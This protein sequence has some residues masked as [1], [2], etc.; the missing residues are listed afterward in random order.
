[1]FREAKYNLWHAN[2]AGRRNLKRGIPA[3]QAG[4]PKYNA[5]ADDIDFQIEADFIGLM[6]PGLY[7]PAIDIGMRAGRVMNYGDGI[8]G[9]IFVSCMYAAG[10]FESDPRR[11]VEQG[12][13]CIPAKS[14]YA[15]L[16]VDLLN[17]SK[18]YPGDWKKA[19]Q[20][21]E[22]KWDRDDVCPNGA[23]APFNID[24]KLNG[25]YIALGLLYGQRDFGRTIEISTRAG[26][27]SD[28]NPASAAGILGVMLGYKGIPDEWK[29]GIDALADKK[30]NFTDFSFHG[31]VDSTYKRAVALA[32]R[33]GGEE[34]D[35]VLTVKAARP[36]PPRLEVWNAGKPVER[37]NSAD[38]RVDLEGQLG[39]RGAAGPRGETGRPPAP[40]HGEGRRGRHLLRG[41]RGRG[42]GPVPAR[43]RQTPG[44]PG[45]QA[46]PRPGRVFGRA[47]H[48]ERRSRVARLQFEERKAYGAVGGA[49]RTL[50]AIHRFRGRDRRADRVPLRGG[51]WQPSRMSRGG[52]MSRWGRF[53][54]S[55]AGWWRFV[56]SC[57]SAC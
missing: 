48:Q 10:F 56:P 57:A 42:G 41:H 3:A 53:P 1:M 38:S 18:Q 44:L 4:L 6:A 22:D 37:V 8:Y 39:R 7:Q 35:G 43:R 16:M 23:L 24:A 19:W 55:S 28:C 26:Q 2:L 45:W 5:H 20:M 11:V 12:L 17:W 54:T 34:R 46:G 36:K 33:G 15:L 32:K 40:L 47:Q 21:V 13:A 29:G 49:G 50:C 9:G 27:D 52:R 25:A 51:R 14:P 31:I 30:F